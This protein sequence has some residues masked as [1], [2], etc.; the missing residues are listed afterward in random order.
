M[1]ICILKKKT[2]RTWYCVFVTVILNL[3]SP[4]TV[5]YTQPDVNLTKRRKNGW[6]LERKKALQNDCQTLAD[7]I[8]VANHVHVRQVLLITNDLD[9]C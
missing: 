7:L 8:K 6:T 3:L 1:T 2:A 5:Q 9:L 4:E